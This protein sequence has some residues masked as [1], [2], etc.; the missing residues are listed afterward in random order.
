MKRMMKIASSVL[1]TSF[2]TFSSFSWASPP[3]GIKQIPVFPTPLGYISDYAELINREWHSRIRDVCKELEDRTGVEMIVVTIESVK[4]YSH[5]RE[6]AEKLYE[7]WR[8]GT[9]QKEKGILLLALQKERQA[10]V[11]LGRNLL[12]IIS[13]PELDILSERHLIPMFRNHKFGESLYQATVE[14][15]SASGKVTK[16]PNKKK[17]SSSAGF[18][19]NVGVVFAM[20]YALWRFTRPERKH[21]FQRWRR[22]VYWGT[23]QGGFGGG[24][25]GFGGNT[26]GQG[27]S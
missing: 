26:N 18:W 23:G 8:I 13:K 21:P 6:Y 16:E 22:R 27:L 19:M 4:P 14:L 5:A 17:H 1:L 3:Y 2:L 15:A 11:V 24:L 9:V 20:F 10:V 7:E 12:P 25:G